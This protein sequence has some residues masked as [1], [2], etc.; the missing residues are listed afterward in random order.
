MK[1]VKPHIKMVRFP[2]HT[3]IAPLKFKRRRARHHGWSLRYFQP[4][5]SQKSATICCSLCLHLLATAIRRPKCRPRAATHHPDGSE[6]HGGRQGE[7]LDHCNRFHALKSHFLLRRCGRHRATAC[8]PTITSTSP[9]GPTPTWSPSTT[10]GHTSSITSFPWNRRS[11]KCS[12]RLSNRLFNT[13]SK[14]RICSRP[15]PWTGF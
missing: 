8:C 15:R 13:S 3:P 6:R 5:A 9:P 14:V 4:R 2:Q 10:S 11:T 7:F 12:S 1:S